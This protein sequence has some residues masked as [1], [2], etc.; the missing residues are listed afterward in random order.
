MEP[1]YFGRERRSYFGSL[2][3]YALIVGNNLSYEIDWQLE[4]KTNSKS[5]ICAEKGSIENN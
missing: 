1:S 2:M 4:W 3:V 5:T